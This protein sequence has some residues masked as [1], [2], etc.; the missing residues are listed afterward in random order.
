MGEARLCDSCGGQIDAEARFCRH[1]GAAQAAQ[2]EVPTPA[3]AGPATASPVPPS[4][5]AGRVQQAA[6]G[7]DDFAAALAAQLNTPG[8]VAGLIAG[9]GTALITVVGGF[10]IAIAT[11]SSSVIGGYD[12]SIVKEAMLQACALVGASF[13]ASG[14]EVDVARAFGVSLEIQT[15]PLLGLLIPIG[16]M[17]LL[18]RLQL[19]R[20]A[21]VPPLQR[22]GF[23]VA[24]AVPFALLMIIPA[25]IAEVESDGATLAPDAGAVFGLSLLFGI[26]GAL[27]GAQAVVGAA[28]SGA[29]P[30]LGTLVRP[31]VEAL[32]ALLIALALAA[33]V[34]TGLVFVQTLRD[35]GNA[36]GDRST[37]GAA[38]ENSLY[39]VEHGLH[40][41][42]LG[43][44]ATFDLTGVARA[45]ALF[46]EEENLG[47]N[48]DATGIFLPLPVEKAD[49][50]INVDRENAEAT[51]RVF[52]YSDAMPGWAFVLWIV[53]LIPIPI[54]LALYAGFAIARSAGANGPAQAALWGAATGPVWAIALV[55]LNALAK[56]TDLF[57]VFGHADGDSVFGW[58]LLIATVA[59]GLGGLLATRSQLT[60]RAPSPAQ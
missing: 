42:E 8:I 5:A 55:L 20:T 56:G 33:V 38:V 44:F 58:V 28:V 50:L 54:L 39:T 31:I 41:V 29:V 57:T 49:K 35:A 37:V 7:A 10:V 32:R 40:G 17:A 47:S 30:S 6:P 9:A 53:I 18:V 13:S 24:A 14:Q 27:I 3:A 1:C 12:A 48:D 15:M 46:D 51:Y 23:A 21:D 59:G 45:A 26:V 36:V 19:S 2:P 16:G 22:L 11:T 25:T 52:D 34:M 43:T 4:S 60:P